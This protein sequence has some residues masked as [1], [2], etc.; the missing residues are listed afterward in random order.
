GVATYIGVNQ[1]NTSTLN[2]ATDALDGAGGYD[3]LSLTIS[4]SS[5]PSLTIDPTKVRNIE[6]LLITG[7]VASSTVT[8]SPTNS[9]TELVITGNTGST[10]FTGYGNNVTKLGVSNQR[11]GTV[12]FAVDTTTLI[13]ANDALTVTLTDQGTSSTPARVDISVT[14]TNYYETLN[15]VSNGTANYVN[16]PTGSTQTSL[17]RVN[18]S[19]AAPLTL[20]TFTAGLG[21]KFYLATTIDASAATG[22]VTIGAGTGTTG[23]GL[24]DQTVI[25]GTGAN[26]VNFGAN[27]GVSNLDAN[28][29]VDGSRGTNDTI[30]I[31]ATNGITSAA[32]A[33][34]TGIENFRFNPNGS[35]ITQDTSQLPTG[36]GLQVGGSFGTVT[37]TNLA[38]NAAVD[39]FK[40][41]SALTL[42]MQLANNGG[43]STDAMTLRFNAA[44]GVGAALGVLSDITGL[45]TLNIVSNGT[46]TNTINDD[47][48]TARHVVTGS[49][50][51]SLT[52]GSVTGPVT[53]DGSAFT[54]KLDI[55]GP[56][57]QSLTVI[58]GT[59]KDSFSGAGGSQFIL[60]VQGQNF[61]SGA[62]V[63]SAR[64]TGGTI[65][66][67][68]NVAAGTGAA[69]DL[70][71]GVSISDGSGNVTGVILTF[72]AD[73]HDFS[74]KNAAGTAFTGLAKGAVAQGL[75]AGDTPVVQNL[76][77]GSGAIGAT[78]NVSLITASAAAFTTD[79][80]TLFQTA[81]DTDEITGLAADGNYLVSVYDTTHNRTV[82]AVVNTG[83]S[84]AGDTTLSA[85]D[86]TDSG[87]AL[88][89]YIYTA[90]LLNNVSQGTAF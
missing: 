49:T 30:A 27:G 74:L 3:T 62:D 22:G 90:S 45:E 65:A 63:I 7:A 34:V 5:N 1:Q 51:L 59:G 69:T 79:I 55:T 83:A 25:L 38:N 20:A 54:G 52:F 26:L 6:R 2:A 37:L 71:G 23:L 43:G 67:V 33:H 48:V 41:N 42:A 13:G 75:T 17:T 70:L 10:T 56:S 72:S 60:G 21:D 64:G 40:A 31:I 85:A 77:P 24:A 82:V 50:D 61:Q 58:G 28:D 19:G 8:L 73:D 80:K 81:F 84:G 46:G 15:I 16:L 47:R 44:G 39:V 32:L 35:G 11:L 89:G 76:G 68:G 57:G 18:I 14:G 88:I 12:K 9:F 86:F 87:V 4:G 36:V 29:T 66:F 53:V 78:A